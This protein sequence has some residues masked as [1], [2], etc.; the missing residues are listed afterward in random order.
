VLTPP[1]NT[2]RIAWL[3]LL[4]GCCTLAQ[5]TTTDDIYAADPALRRFVDSQHGESLAIELGRLTYRRRWNEVLDESL[6]AFAPRGTWDE[7]HPAWAP[8]REALAQA[9]RE[10]SVRWLADHRDEIRLV[11]N[12]QSMQ[13]MT[14]DERRQTTE[15]FES[16]AGKVFLATRESFLRERAYGLPLEIEKASLDQVKRAHND[17][18]KVLLALPEDGD[19]KVIFDFFHGGPGD[20][21]QQVQVKQWGEIVANVFSNTL[22]AYVQRHK[23]ELSTRLRGAVPS[24]PAASDKVYL[25]TVAMG[26]DNAFTV[27][28]EHYDAMRLVGKYTLTYAPSDLHWGDIAVATPG[29]KP[30]DKRSLYRDPSGRLGDR[31]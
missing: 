12:Q 29:I 21:L 28:V 15:F 4:A 31:P 7:T 25:G 26:A 18:E 6:Y 9:L 3:A 8:A 17:A 5:A 20:K 27:I 16:S 23:A 2:R 11:V 13:G 1:R 24:M 14:E 30:G 19:G 10:E 22:E